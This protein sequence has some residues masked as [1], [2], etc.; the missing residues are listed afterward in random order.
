MLLVTTSNAL[1]PSLFMTAHSNA[2]EDDFSDRCKPAPWFYGPDCN[3]K[4]KQDIKKKGKSGKPS[5]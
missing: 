2:E 1:E 3:E 4:P 5:G